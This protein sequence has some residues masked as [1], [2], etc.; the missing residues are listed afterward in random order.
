MYLQ[1]ILNGVSFRAIGES[2]PEITSLACDTS[3]VKPGCLF[4]CLKGNKHDGHDFFRKAIGDGAVAIVC[5]R[6]LETQAL[7]IVVDD[8][9]SVMAIAAKNF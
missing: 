9:R 6:P 8:V 5:E 7:Q 3:Q 2:N 4:F 1:Q